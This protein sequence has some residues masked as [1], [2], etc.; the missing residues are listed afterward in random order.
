MECSPS[1]SLIGKINVVKMN[2]LPKYVFL[3]Q[4]LPIKKK[5]KKES[6][7]T[8]SHFLWNGRTPRIGQKVLQNCKFNGGLSPPNFQLYYWAVNINR[9]TLWSKSVDVPWC[10]LEVQSC[11]SSSLPALTDSVTVNPSGFYGL[12]GSALG[13]TFRTL[14]YVMLCFS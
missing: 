11:P 1:L 13:G 12:M 10:Q 2:V 5:K 7:K 4:C 8:I 9:I 6:D 3:F 14:S